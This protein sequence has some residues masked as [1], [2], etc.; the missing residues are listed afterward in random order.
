MIF[1]HSQPGL[2][3][4][5]AAEK[6]EG[7]SEFD[8]LRAR[9]MRRRYFLHALNAVENAVVASTALEG[10]QVKSPKLLQ[11]CFAH[12]SGVDFQGIFGSL[13]EMQEM[14]RKIPECC[15][16]AKIPA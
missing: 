2:N 9:S 16:L 12:S 5:V 15:F 7:Q 3:G 11:R 8:F 6:K 4:S 10:S 14:T 1:G 13:V